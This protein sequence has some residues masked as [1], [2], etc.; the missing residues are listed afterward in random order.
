[1]AEHTSRPNEIAAALAR[2][3]DGEIDYLYG[4]LQA[5]SRLDQRQFLRSD[6]LAV[7]RQ[8]VRDLRHALNA[9]VRLRGLSSD[10]DGYLQVV[11][12]MAEKFDKVSVRGNREEIDNYL[13]QFA[14]VTEPMINPALVAL[15][16]NRGRLSRAAH[17]YRLGTRAEHDNLG[18]AIL[19]SPAFFLGMNPSRSTLDGNDPALEAD[20]DIYLDTDDPAEA[21]RVVE[22]VDKLGELLGYDEPHE[23][24]I[25]SGSFIRRAK[26]RA[27]Q[28]FSSGELWT[29]LYKVERAIE[30]VALDSHQA[31]FDSKEA[32]AVSALLQSLENIP[33]ACIRLGSIFLVK[34]QDERGPVLLVRNLSQLEMR[35]LK[36]YPEIQTEPRKA[37]EALSTAVA[38]MDHDEPPLGSHP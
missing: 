4:A 25:R 29:R 23:V 5:I 24:D 28:L 32:E 12:A 7:G 38:E 18:V 35:A 13:S 21:Y 14:A 17:P 15:A 36:K 11:L 33:Q 22:A 31:S 16:R 3:P 19:E 10:L 8:A 34:F 1:M 6:W 37:L 26:A 2:L 20:F 30:L 27:V 9:F